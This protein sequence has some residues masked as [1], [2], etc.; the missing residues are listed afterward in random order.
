VNATGPLPDSV[1]D[2]PRRG[3][4]ASSASRFPFPFPFNYKLGLKFLISAACLAALGRW[5][6]WGDL[7]GRSAGIAWL[8]VAAAMLLNIAMQILNAIKIRMLFPPPRPALKG[9]AAVNFIAV[10]FSTFLPGGVG[11]E[12]ARWAYMGR[13]SGSKG[14][15]LAAIL[16]DRV[17]G[18][19]SQILLALTAWMWLG[20]KTLALWVAGPA[21]LFILAASLWAGLWGYRILIKAVGAAVAWY[22]RKR[23]AEQAMP[24]GLGEALAELLS[25]RSL[26][27]KVSALSVLFQLLVVTVFLLLDRS[28]GGHLG[29][30]QAILFLFCFTLIQFLPL[31]LGNWGLS[32]GVFGILYHYAG[33]QG[34]TGVLIALLMRVMMVPAAFAGWILFLARRRGPQDPESADSTKSREPG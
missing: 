31:T 32:E 27:L 9:L 34:E 15:A 24:Q 30:M 4:R 33:A 10:F 7:A 17:T 28:I 29:V 3:R 21:A 18:F 6:D 19:W 5:I 13:E 20:R 23:G 26:F 16:L 11:G 8:P 12:V 22:A 14:R 25:A 2:S 1:K